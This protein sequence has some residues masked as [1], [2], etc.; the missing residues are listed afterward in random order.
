MTAHAGWLAEADAHR[1]CAARNPSAGRYGPAPTIAGVFDG[2][3]LAGRR[4]ELQRVRGLLESSQTSVVLLRGAPGAGSSRLCAEVA[5]EARERGWVVHQAAATPA[6]S[7]IALGALASLLPREGDVDPLALLA[8]APGWLARPGDG[9]LLIV[10]D[11][12]DLLDSASLALLHSMV[13]SAGCSAVLA[14]SSNRE[15]PATVAAILRVGR[16]VEVDVAPLPPDDVGELVGNALG[17]TPDAAMVHALLHATDANL[18]LLAALLADGVE[19]GTVTRSD[20]GLCRWESAPTLG[21]RVVPLTDAWRDG[22]SAQERAPLEFASVAETALEASLL[23][24]LTGAQA[25]GAANAH[26]HLL[27]TQD[28]RRTHVRVRPA[29]HREALRVR[30]PAL[31]GAAVRRALAEA[32]EACGSRRRE[33]QLRTTTWRLDSGQ[34]VPAEALAAAAGRALALEDLELCERLACASVAAGGGVTALALRAR[35][36]IGRQRPAE[37]EEA[38]ARV[39][40]ESLSDPDRADLAILRSTNL[41]RGLQR[42]D[43]ADAL[44]SRVERTIDADAHR[45]DVV[46]TRAYVLYVR[47]K[48]DHALALTDR[49]LG[50]GTA[51]T[52]VARARALTV[53]ASIWAV[54]GL[55]QRALDAIDLA[56]RSPR[57]GRESVR[58]TD[59]EMLATRW[60]ALWYAGRLSEAEELAFERLRVALR[61]RNDRER[62]RLLLQLGLCARAGGRI[63]TS[64]KWLQESLEVTRDSNPFRLVATL[65]AL[66]Q[67]AVQLGD[68]ATGRRCIAEAEAVGAPVCAFDDP[69]LQLARAWVCAA[70]GQL[71]EARARALG[72]AVAAR[73]DG[74]TSLEILALHDVARLGGARSVAQRA[75]ELLDAVEGPLLRTLAE[76]TEALRRGRGEELERNSEAFESFGMLLLAAESGAAASGAHRRS[77]YPGR[78]RS[79][80]RRARTLLERCEGARTPGLASLSDREAITGRERE[81]ASL[82]RDGLHNRAI[83]ERLGVSVRTVEN[84]LH[85]AYAKLDVHDRGELADVLPG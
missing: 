77:G 24:R 27:V 30:L 40:L 61:A 65:A 18:V 2:V 15:I 6:A 60:E 73:S 3:A 80:E 43:D 64:M 11:D 74:C 50:T 54:S 49:V 25:V 29:L 45:L 85:R 55:P 5:R 10:I 48:F 23:E 69:R 17:G 68:V 39:D 62:G 70:A 56:M 76:N 83:A 57:A 32:V 52:S 31:G 41:L 63:R 21:P 33:D 14:L 72:A 35:A 20:S 66:G 59:E 9:R 37:A 13:S 67:A 79:A 81:V 4:L 26:G 42:A 8:R 51:T 12:A 44:L 71:S 46:A 84:L 47:G 7:T 82:A 34:G 58:P 22:L 1:R 16:A 53:R 75:S 78:A 19:A 38:L 28:G 36:L